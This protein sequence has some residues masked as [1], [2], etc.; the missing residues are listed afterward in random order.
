MNYEA[1]LQPKKTI[2]IEKILLAREAGKLN[3]YLSVEHIWAEKN[4]NEAG[5]NNRKED[6]FEKRRLA[7]CLASPIKK[8]KKSTNYSCDM[9]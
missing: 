7:A 4:R 8:T 1:E 3:D 2:P 5:A 9:V 6:K